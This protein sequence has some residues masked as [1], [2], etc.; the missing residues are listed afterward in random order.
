MALGVLCL[1]LF[2]CF[3][4]DSRVVQGTESDFWDISPVNGALVFFGVA[5]DLIDLQGFSNRDE[6]IRKALEDAARRVAM[7]RYLEG[8]Y[9]QYNFSG[10]GYLDWDYRVE[11]QLTFDQDYVAYVEHLQFDPTGDIYIDGAN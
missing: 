8:S 1:S 10:S 7:F 5:G 2:S 11:T 4:L 6:M 9:D 3:T